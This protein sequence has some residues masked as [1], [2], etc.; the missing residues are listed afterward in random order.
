MNKTMKQIQDCPESMA[1]SQKA[2]LISLYRQE[3]CKKEKIE[4]YVGPH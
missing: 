4:Y 2:N 1:T 3:V